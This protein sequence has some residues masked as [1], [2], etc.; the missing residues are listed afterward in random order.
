MH[1]IPVLP[2]GVML[3]IFLPYVTQHKNHFYI[4]FIL[5][6]NGPYSKQVIHFIDTVQYTISRHINLMLLSFEDT[7]ICLLL[8]YFLLVLK[9]VSY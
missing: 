8:Y 6:R 9:Y 7:Q 1:I 4:Y 5:N 2:N 3:Q